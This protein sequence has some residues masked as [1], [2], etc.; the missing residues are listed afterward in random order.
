MKTIKDLVEFEWDKGNIGKNKKHGVSDK[1]S[2][3]VFFDNLKIIFKDELHSHKEIRFILIGRTKKG[4]LL[5]I[6]YTKRDKK[7]RIISA[8]DINRKEVSLYEKEVK[9]S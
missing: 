9:N 6:V 1:E 3:E 4:R 7:F 2:E 5:Y 8:R